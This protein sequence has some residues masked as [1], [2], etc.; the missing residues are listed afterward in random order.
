MYAGFLATEFVAEE[1]VVECS[2]G[3]EEAGAQEKEAVGEEDGFP[4]GLILKDE[5]GDGGG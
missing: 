2:E 3:V 4:G 1:A 5:W